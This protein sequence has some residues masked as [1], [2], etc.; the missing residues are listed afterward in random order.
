MRIFPDHPNVNRIKD[1][2]LEMNVSETMS[3]ERQ[4]NLSAIVKQNFP[5]WYIKKN[6]FHSDKYSKNDINDLIYDDSGGW[7]RGSPLCLYERELVGEKE[8]SKVKAKVQHTDPAKSLNI[9]SSIP[10]GEPAD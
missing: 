3:T 7:H 9:W 8:I 10:S 1:L 6:I 4:K 2:A 5:N